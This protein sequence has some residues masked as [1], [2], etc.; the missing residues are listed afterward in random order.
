MR[1]LMQG[2][3]LA[4]PHIFHRAE[5]HFA[6]KT[7]TAATATG[8]VT[9]TYQLWARRVRRSVDLANEIMAHPAVAEAARPGGGRYHYRDPG[10]A[11][12]VWTG[13][14]PA[15]HRLPRPHSRERS[16]WHWLLAVA[17]VVPLLTPLYNRARPQLWGLPFFYW[18]Q[19]AF[20][21]M[22]ALVTAIVYLA[23]KKRRGP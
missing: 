20:S 10:A 11:R 18:C 1:G 19:I 9:T 16:R 23:T 4:V 7:I 14:A 2:R 6:H 12:G 13:P 5:R 15:E 21:G 17:V 22:V 8:E 3:P